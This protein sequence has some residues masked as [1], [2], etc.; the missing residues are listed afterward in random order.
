MRLTGAIN[1]DE[2][3]VDVDVEAHG[4]AVIEE[5]RRDRQLMLKVRHD[6]ALERAVDFILGLKALAE[7]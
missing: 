7:R 6:E 5:A 2:R 1:R 4:K 3:R